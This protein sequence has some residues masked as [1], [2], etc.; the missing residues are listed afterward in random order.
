[1]IEMPAR[2]MTEIAELAPISAPARKRGPPFKPPAQ[3]RTTAQNIKW[4]PRESELLRAAA[5]RQGIPRA[6]FVRR[7]TLRAIAEALR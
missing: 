4:L 7:A 5:L 6:T 1:M 3:R 2:A